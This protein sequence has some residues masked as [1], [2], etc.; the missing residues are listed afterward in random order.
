MKKTNRFLLKFTLVLSAFMCQADPMILQPN[1]G[2]LAAEFPT[3]QYSV[4]TMIITVSALF[5][6]IA[7]LISGSVAA[8]LGKK[9]LLLAGSLLFGCG[10]CFTSIAPSFALIILCRM[11]E[12]L[13][14]G[15]VITISMTLIPELFPDEKESNR[16]LGMNAVATALWGTVLGTAAG[17]LGVISWKYAN[18]L[19]LTGFVILVFQL[20]VIPSDR[21]LQRH[22]T[23]GPAG[24]VTPSAYSVAI[25]AFLFAVISTIFMTSVAA[26]IIEAGL[27]DSSEAG[28][29]VSVMTVGSF[30]IGLAFARIFESL[31]SMTPVVSYIAMAVGVILPVLTPS[32]SIACVGAFVFGMGYGTYFP[33]INAEAIRISP[34]ESTDA[35]MSLINGAYYIG[36]FASSFLMAG[37]GSLFHNQTA[38]FYYKF[39][40]V[41]FILFV[42]Y[43]LIRAARERKK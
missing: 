9:K 1:L 17:Y 38:M 33:Y 21:E 28:V 32:Y 2:S 40:A 22:T 18:F 27:G 41:V 12:G 29:T 5:L 19:Y 43:Y 3:L 31:K 13:G 16:I 37:I 7:A 34:P 10:G 14:A 4:I 26:F 8:R 11:L 20:L 24:K 35:N 25:L 39:M 23:E 36:M 15:F 42:I 6:G 30:L